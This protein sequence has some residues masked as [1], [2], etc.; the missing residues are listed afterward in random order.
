MSLGIARSFRNSA[1][2]LI[3]AP[4]FDYGKGSYDSYLANG[5]HGSGDS[6]Y[7]AGGV[8]LRQIN[9]SGFYYEGSFRGGRAETDFL[10]DNF[11]MSNNDVSIGYNASSPI[12]A[13]HVRVGHLLR[14]DKN[15]LLHV[16]GIYSHNHQNSMSTHLSTG[17]HY[18]FDSVDN[19]KFRLGY[20]L[21]SRVS[22]VSRLYSGLAYQYEFTGGTCASY[23]GYKTPSEEIKGSSGMLELGWQIKANR[24]VPWLLD[25][26]VTGWVGQEQGVTATA[27]MKKD[28]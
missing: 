11:K 25:L 4:L 28:F 26:N 14:M 8:L 10:S 1:G 27:K 7:L 22:N 17:E 2:T 20:R 12:F 5:I 16:Y 19:G 13:G 9:D 15:N 24:K 18:N 23:K 3:F 21:T 6:K